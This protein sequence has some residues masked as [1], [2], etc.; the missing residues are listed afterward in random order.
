MKALEI[1][2]NNKQNVILDLIGPAYPPA[3]KELKSFIKNNSRIKNR[4]NYIGQMEKSLLL[5]Y[6]KKSDIFVFA[7]SSETFGMILL[8]AMASGLPIAC[9]NKT[10]MPEI[11]GDCGEY[12]NPDNPMLIANAIKSIVKNTVRD[13]R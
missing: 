3:L 2:I 5:E 10:A 9:S 12:F 6:Y 4:V 11:L 7:S 1:L 13:S 8:E